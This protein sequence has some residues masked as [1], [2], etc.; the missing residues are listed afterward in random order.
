M[1]FDDE[2]CAAYEL[3]AHR[4]R[5]AE[6]GEDVEATTFSQAVDP[7][8]QGVTLCSHRPTAHSSP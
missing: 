5:K 1:N 4:K 6:H 3:E 2:P 7:L 8:L